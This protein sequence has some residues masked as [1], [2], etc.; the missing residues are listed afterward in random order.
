MKI[1]AELIKCVILTSC[2]NNK[3]ASKIEKSWKIDD[4]KENIQYFEWNK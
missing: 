2:K 1:L 3:N 4:L